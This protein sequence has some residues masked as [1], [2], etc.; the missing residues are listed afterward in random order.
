M[1]WEILFED[2]DKTIVKVRTFD[3]REKIIH[4]ISDPGLNSI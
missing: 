3:N 1:F 4:F 2:A